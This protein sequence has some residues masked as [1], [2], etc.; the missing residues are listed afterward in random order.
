MFDV[1]LSTVIEMPFFIV[2]STVDHETS[3][4]NIITHKSD[5]MRRPKGLRVGSLQG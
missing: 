1:R 2:T 5:A 3:R 4:K